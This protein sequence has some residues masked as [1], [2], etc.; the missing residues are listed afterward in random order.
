M[1]I[2]AL[3]RVLSGDGT[4]LF[5]V[6]L[7]GHIQSRKLELLE[8]HTHSSLAHIAFGHTYYGTVL[9]R[10]AM[11]FNNSPVGTEFLAVLDNQAVGSEHGVDMS[12]NLAR[13][14]TSGGLGQSKWR[15]QGSSPTTESLINITPMQV[16]IYLA[17]PVSSTSF[18]SNHCLWL[19]CTIPRS[20]IVPKMEVGLPGANNTC[21]FYAQYGFVCIVCDIM[22]ITT[23]SVHVHVHVHTHSLF[24]S[25]FFSEHNTCTY[26]QKRAGV[27]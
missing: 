5:T 22:H 12:E 7:C 25:L 9:T 4:E 23:H 18:C 16:C 21:T 27:D 24:L 19:L 13:A 6:T 1:F 10:K 2:H 8:C 3:H 11:L 14:C 26:V 20:I 17:L 15:E